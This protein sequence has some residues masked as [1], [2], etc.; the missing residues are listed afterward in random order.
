MY[1][2]YNSP[3]PELS[4]NPF[5]EHTSNPLTR[6]PDVGSY[7]SPTDP[8]FT[9]WSGQPNGVPQQQ[10]YNTYNPQAGQQPYATGWSV[11][12]PT[13]QT[14]G[15]GFG[16][17][18]QT[19]GGTRFQP[20]SSF[21]QQLSSAMDVGGFVQGGPGYQQQPQQQFT[22]GYGTP[23]GYNPTGGIPNQIQTS[24]PPYQQAINSGYL[25]EFDPYGSIGQGGWDRP[26][27][28]Q[29]PQQQQGGGLT[30]GGALN[31]Q[32]D[33][34]PR[35]FIQKYKAELEAWDSYSWKQLMNSFE[36]LSRAWERRMH[37]LDM[38]VKQLSTSWS[39]AGQHELAEYKNVLKDSESSFCQS[40]LPLVSLSHPLTFLL[41]S[42]AASAY[43]L[44]EA[45]QGY[46][47]STDM[48][49]KR[50]VREAVNAALRSLPE[51]PSPNY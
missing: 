18:Q 50:R 23:N 21:G 26:Q 6:Y 33:L 31:S 51:Y 49:S 13:Y 28:S 48:A 3:P 39:V 32:S 11:G 34:H 36:S 35:E 5:L 10:G 41:A 7:T 12:S 45:L 29:Q 25:S 42:V 27:Q 9:S 46:R 47:Q 24:P 22:P 37:E 38:R 40:I 44:K 2:S 20:S 19:G 43:Q 14:Q 17:P 8:Q 30:N 4:N 16:Y 15:S 1:G